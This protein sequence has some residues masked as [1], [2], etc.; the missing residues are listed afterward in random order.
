MIERKE[1]IK[2]VTK[3]EV[4]KLSNIVKRK[5]FV[6]SFADWGIWLDIPELN[7]QVFKAVLP[8]NAAI[9][10]TRFKS[11]NSFGN[12]YSTVYRYSMNQDEYRSYPESES[13]IVE[14]LKD[15]KV[16]YVE[17]KKNAS[18]TDKA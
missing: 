4:M 8:N 17:E 16:R 11:Y 14:K 3:E 5:E 1:N 18:A 15:L 2:M 10:I 9:F 6:N 13:Y 7:V 12:K